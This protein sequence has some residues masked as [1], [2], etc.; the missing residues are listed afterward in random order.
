MTLAE[1]QYLYLTTV[2]RK[3]GLPREIEI[4]FTRLGGRFYLIAEKRERANWVQNILGNPQVAFRVGGQKFSGVGRV[5][6]EANEADL[7]QRVCEGFDRKY[8]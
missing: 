5:I 7:R 3:T 1:E 4:W 2:G 6:N 8:G